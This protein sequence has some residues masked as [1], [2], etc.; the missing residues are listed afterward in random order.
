MQVLS[1]IALA[2]LG[3]VLLIMIFQFGIVG[4]VMLLLFFAFGS[5]LFC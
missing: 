4:T 5:L 1:N 2:L 3:I